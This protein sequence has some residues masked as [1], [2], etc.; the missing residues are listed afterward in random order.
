MFHTVKQLMTTAA[1]ALSVLTLGGCID[2]DNPS[3]LTKGLVYCS[4]GSPET[5]NPQL[6]TSGTTIDAT[7]HQL[8]N[9]LLAFNKTD[10]SLI[11]SIAKSWHVNLDGRIITFY[12]RRDISFH[13]TEYF[14]P[15]RQLNADDVLFSFNRILDVNH[16]YH[17]VSGGKYPFF[18][19]VGFNELVNT[20]ERINDYTI[21]FKL[22]HPDSSFLANLATNFAVILSKE[23]ADQLA[24]KGQKQQLDLQPIGTGPYKLK[25]YHQGSLIR[26]YRHPDYWQPASNIEQLL[27]DI[28]PSNSVR[29]TKLFAHE[30]DV[31]AYPVAK[32]KI[33]QRPDL[34]LEEVTSF[35]VAFLAFNTRKKPFADPLVRRAIAHAIN[36]EAIVDAVYDDQASVAQAL[37]PKVSWAYS[38]QV[39]TI[40]Y[41]LEKAKALLVQAGYPQGFSMDIWAMPVQ[42]AYNPNAL[43][44]AKLL[45]SELAE[46]G[47][48]V[49]IISF[50]WSTFLKKLARGEHHSVLIGWSADHP[51]PD[52]FFRPLLSCAAR[53]TGRNRAF[54][55]NESFDLLIEQALLTTNTNDRKHFYLAAQNLIAE[56]VP[57]LPIAHS[58]RL[59]AKL[60]SV[61]GDI[62]TS[63]GGVDFSRVDKVEEN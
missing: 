59:Q 31:I 43:K 32:E 46:I 12:L 18:Q 41:S 15:T 61:K 3:F 7:S 58:K 28:T 14:T 35:N 40:D 16:P 55:C 50:E 34:I 23:Y 49:N 54:W 39:A 17:R 22:K 10:N 27:F 33:K 47:V 13:Q 19:S 20:I 37:I 11:P 29:L 60:K 48:K 53:D 62:L 36:R 30:C 21:R 6:V 4:E 2:D 51:D 44:M 45:Q 56:Q 38:D 25:E 63:F 5:F 57:L 9:R 52:N 1:L 8:Y 42:R 24:A 26:Y